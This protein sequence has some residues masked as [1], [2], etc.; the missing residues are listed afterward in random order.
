[1]AAASR[2]ALD[3]ARAALAAALERFAPEGPEETR[4][5]AAVLALVRTE[6]ACFS[7]S[8][9]VPGHVTASAFIVCRRTRKVL[10]HHHRRLD[11]WLQLGGHDDG[12]RDA[13]ATALREAREESGLT[14]L[15]FL[16]PAILDVDVHSIPAARGEP[17][18]LHHDVRYA[19]ATGRPEAIQRDE[20][21]S[22]SLAWFT[23]EAAAERMGE[24]G[25]RRALAKIA[26]L[27][28]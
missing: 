24:V 14:D 15:V 12:E 4:D 20:A 7:R 21:E 1:V 28:P 19:L 16:T 25:G 8:T 22:L 2:L 27:L 11:A 6:P 9:F 5:A 13:P 17:A 3:P 23:L 18:H 10:L 26:R